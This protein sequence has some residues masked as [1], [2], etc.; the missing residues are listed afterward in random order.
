MSTTAAAA[1]EGWGASLGRL[2]A[3]AAGVAM[4]WVGPGLPWPAWL[5]GPE[6]PANW[7]IPTVNVFYPFVSGAD[8]VFTAFILVELVALAVPAFAAAAVGGAARAP[9]APR[10]DGRSGRGLGRSARGPSRHLHARAAPPGRPPLRRVRP[11]IR[12]RVASG[13]VGAGLARRPLRDRQ[14]LLRRPPGGAAARG[15]AARP[16]P[17]PPRAVRRAHGAVA[18]RGGGLRHPRA[19][20]APRAGRRRATAGGRAR[21][22]LPAPPRGRVARRPLVTSLPGSVVARDRARGAH[23]LDLPP[24]RPRGRSGLQL[25]LRASVPAA[26]APRAGAGLSSSPAD[27]REASLDGPSRQPGLRRRHARP[28]SARQ[29]HVSWRVP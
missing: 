9:S 16:D 5:V 17:S 8:A 11:P 20:R 25:A 15:L 24:P 1:E 4:A 22:R 7:G 26:G 23:D 14:R 29:L 19:P 2:L 6:I 27:E 3:T 12:R 21:L 10:R 13:L 28:R 18:G